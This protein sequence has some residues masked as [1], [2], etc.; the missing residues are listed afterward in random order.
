MSYTKSLFREFMSKLTS[1]GLLRRIP[2]RHIKIVFF[3]LLTAI[4]SSIDERTNK[5]LMAKYL[6]HFNR[7]NVDNERRF[8]LDDKD[9]KDTS[10]LL[11]QL[12]FNHL[13]DSF[14]GASLEFPRWSIIGCRFSKNMA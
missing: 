4:G 1:R 14:S 8:S 9:F 6:D 10:E 5:Q 11:D 7:S 3:N 2:F 12:I 13:S